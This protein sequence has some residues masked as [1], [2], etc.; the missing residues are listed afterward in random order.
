MDH[1]VL[2]ERLIQA[3]FNLFPFDVQSALLD[4]GAFT[5]R[6]G[7]D[8]I[9]I[10]TIG[11]DGPS[12]DRSQLYQGIRGAIRDVGSAIEIEDSDGL[13]WQLLTRPQGD[14]IEFLLSGGEKHYYLRDHSAL[15]DDVAVRVGWLEKAASEVFLDRENSRGWLTRMQQSALSDNDFSE[16]MVDI[17][18]SP[19]S[20]ILTL[21][22]DMGTMRME[23]ARLVPHDF[24]Y[25]E[26]LVGKLEQSTTFADYIE[27]GAKVCVE[28][29]Q[30]YKGWQSFVFSLLMCSAG[31]IAGCIKIDRLNHSELVQAYEWIAKHGDPISR[32]GAVEVALAHLDVVP[33]LAPFIELIVEALL[34]DDPEDDGGGFA[35][36][37][38]M[39]VMTASELAR[40]RILGDVPPFYFRQAA[41]AHASLMIRAISEAGID[42]ASV[43]QWARTTGFGLIYFLQG[44]VDLRREPRWLPDYVSAE[45]LRFEFIGRITNAVH[46]NEDKI[47]V[48]SLSKLLLGP[49]SKLMQATQWPF[50]LLP[51]PMEGAIAAKRPY[52]DEWLVEVKAALAADRLEAKAFAGLVNCALLF[53]M[54]E[55]MASMAAD[56]LRRVRFSLE[57]TE[58]K[59]KNF[60]LVVG[61]ATLAAVTR[62]RNLADALRVF[63][64]VMRRRKRLAGD[65]NEELRIVLTTAAS[66]KDPEEWARFSGEWITEIVFETSDKNAAKAFLPKLRRLV[67]IEP[68]LAKHCARADAALDAFTH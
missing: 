33:V 53:D 51:G 21:Q 63:T 37:S 13:V 5:Q 9:G 16:L 40:K 45:Q 54:E 59:D 62:S 41:I 3:A 60:D 61:L 8:T 43:T 58:D 34:S 49:N 29:L 64:R 10:L 4:D 68:M 42:V 18:L 2:K 46:L 56:A 57:S 55:A 44:L 24:R 7:I 27:T 11:P 23:P 32:I 20:F 14:G 1:S 35:I 65:L 28:S 6:W 26:R 48:D 12:F 15:A 36:L 66:F 50:P 38:S 31:S 67:K 39:V 19:R 47:K 30:F 22:N 17:R 52:P 25:Y